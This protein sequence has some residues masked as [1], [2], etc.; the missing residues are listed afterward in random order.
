MNKGTAAWHQAVFEHAAS[1][2]VRVG[3]KMLRAR[4]RR[5][6]NQC[7]TLSSHL[8]VEVVEDAA[9]DQQLDPGGQAARGQHRCRQGEQPNGPV[10][11]QAG[12]SRVLH[13]QQSRLRN[14]GCW[15]VQGR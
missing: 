14:R 4:N 2:S 12:R 1:A 8:V 13:T 5:T 6:H 7:L 11:E 15:P 9:K 3:R 10:V